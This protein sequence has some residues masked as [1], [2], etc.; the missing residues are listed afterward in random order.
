MK[1][2][3]GARNRRGR[4]ATDKV[5]LMKDGDS[6]A[7]G[8][9]VWHQ[10]FKGYTLATPKRGG[11]HEVSCQRCLRTVQATA[12]LGASVPEMIEE[13]NEPIFNAEQMLRL[14]KKDRYLAFMLEDMCSKGHER[15]SAL[16]VLF[17]GNILE[18]S[19]FTAEY[20]TCR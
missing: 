10:S 4:R 15:D 6:T 16:L 19:A 3:R 2:V 14:T 1:I 18:D 13:T 9:N 7:C 11:I 20:E 8:V 12:A 17:N 5:H